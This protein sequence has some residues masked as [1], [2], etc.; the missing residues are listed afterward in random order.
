[1][2]AAWQPSGQYFLSCSEQFR[3][4][5]NLKTRHTVSAVRRLQVLFRKRI[6]DTL[7]NHTRIIMMRSYNASGQYMTI[8]CTAQPAD[9]QQSCACTKI[10]VW[11][12][13]LEAWLSPGLYSIMAY[14]LQFK[15]RPLQ[16]IEGSH[17]RPRH[18][19]E[20]WLILL[21]ISLLPARFSMPAVNDQLVK[22]F[23]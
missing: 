1:M 8:L 13:F 21:H 15:G 19:R 12:L 22:Q 4:T 16:P 7:A 20:D 9:N 17:P 10:I 3:H 23:P 18:C 2:H 5:L 11:S 14:I 6:P